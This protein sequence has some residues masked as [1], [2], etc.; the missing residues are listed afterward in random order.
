MVIRQ[1]NRMGEVRRNRLAL[2]HHHAL[3]RDPSRNVAAPADK[4]VSR[5]RHG[6]NFDDSPLG[7]KRCVRSPADRAAF[8]RDGIDR[9]RIHGQDVQCEGLGKGAAVG[10]DDLDAKR[11][12]ARARRLA[13]D[14]AGRR[15][16][17]E[18]GGKGSG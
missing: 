1:S 5:I 15:I 7:V 2:H 4:R 3:G 18:T 13:V 14:D 16:E 17:R 6:C 8:G 12:L 11:E 10:V 9:Q